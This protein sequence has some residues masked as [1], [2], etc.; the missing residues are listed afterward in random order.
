M[1]QAG[2][3]WQS[4]KG[5]IASMILGLNTV[6]V[7][8]SMMPF[9]LIKLFLPP[10]ALRRSMDTALNALAQTWISINGWWMAMMQPI[11]WRVS[12]IDTLERK[13]WYLVSSN[14]QSWVDILV[15]DRKR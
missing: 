6:V 8:S 7:F 5:C 9:A 1:K 3:I 11:E 15:Q 14:H 13:A 4:C 10:S 2:T 12:G